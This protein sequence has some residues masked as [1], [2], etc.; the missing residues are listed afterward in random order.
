[1]KVSLKSGDVVLPSRSIS[2]SSKNSQGEACCFNYGFNVEQ[3]LIERYTYQDILDRII[4][5]ISHIKKLK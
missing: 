4:S 3:N 5:G 2:H 1:M